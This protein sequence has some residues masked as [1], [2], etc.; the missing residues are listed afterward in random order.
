MISSDYFCVLSNSFYFK[1]E[2]ISSFT[3]DR[4]TV[5]FRETA[6]YPKYI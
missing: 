6:T 2:R 1:G 5:F 4:K 3:F